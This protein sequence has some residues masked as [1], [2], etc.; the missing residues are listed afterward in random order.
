MQEESGTVGFENWFQ[1]LEGVADEIGV[2][3]PRKSVLDT[4]RILE[5]DVVRWVEESHSNSSFR[6]GQIFQGD[7]NVVVDEP[8]GGHN[9]VS[10]SS[11]T[12]RFRLAGS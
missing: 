5:T 6:F 9:D 12:Y 4:I 2:F 7:Q 10:S 8:M 3:L 11:P 1:F